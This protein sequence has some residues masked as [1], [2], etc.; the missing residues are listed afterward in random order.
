[1]PGSESRLKLC[2]RPV[3]V[4]WAVAVAIVVTTA[5]AASSD[6]FAGS[7]T[8]T[9][10]AG[11]KQ[12]LVVTLGS[13]PGSYGITYRSDKSAL[14]NNGPLAGYG[15]GAAGG[16]VLTG[17]MTFTCGQGSPLPNVPFALTSQLVDTI[18]DGFGVVWSRTPEPPPATGLKGRIVFA[19]DRS[20]D[21]EIWTATADGGG[22]R[23]LT[24]TPGSDFSPQWSP[25]GT[26]IVFE[27]DRDHP[28]AD[29]AK[30]TDEI[31]VMNADGTGQKRLTSNNVE[32]W[33]PRW[34]PDG[35]RIVFAA[36]A[37]KA[38][39][40]LDVFVMN[41]DGSGRKDLTPGPGRDFT[42]DWSPDGKRIVFAS[43]DDGD[44]DLYVMNAEGKGVSK[45]FDGAADV[46]GP[47]WSPDGKLIAA[48]S[49]DPLTGEPD[50][51]LASASGFPVVKLTST[52]ASECCAAWSPDGKRLLF[53]GER[54][55]TADLFVMRAS[56]G[57]GI[58]LAIGG[59]ARDTTVDWTGLASTSAACTITGTG[60][61]DKLLGTAKRDVICGLGGNDVL[62]GL[63]GNDV[64]RGG[65][66]ADQLQGGSGNDRLEGGAGTD[67]GNGG[68][69]KDVCKT[70]KRWLCES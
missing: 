3:L 50:I 16:A 11:S 24:K 42:P 61:P 29:P 5:Q 21:L 15:T 68:P 10:A 60:G 45:L 63:K 38:G 33:G 43:D 53:V 58:R 18:V 69:G 14:C 44:Y 46:T 19:S 8:S 64:L 67:S 36:G 39:D 13:T 51:V 55:G 12:A 4:V 26:K 40:D 7:W 70:E 62:K 23:R 65:A 34:S 1:M 2:P 35:K 49:F 57:S 41:A 9:D 17:T 48:Q 28:S 54:N 31:Y 37:P 59:D 47:S 20:G 30:V 66:G 52:L 27:S 25:D 56:D 6:P 32:D 22:L